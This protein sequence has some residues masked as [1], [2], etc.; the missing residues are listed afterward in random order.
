MFLV[1]QWMKQ[2][3]KHV[4]F[5]G[6]VSIGCRQGTNN[7]SAVMLSGEN[8]YSDLEILG[9]VDVTVQTLQ[10]MH[11]QSKLLKH[12]NIVCGENVWLLW[13]I[14]HKFRISTSGKSCQTKSRRYVIGYYDH[15]AN[16]FKIMRDPAVKALW[17]F[18]TFF[19]VFVDVSITFVGFIEVDIRAFQ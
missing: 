14:L 12:C 7:W 1:P 4:R 5:I 13:K 16:W 9:L 18:G 8:N 11:T 19:D 2:Q 17:D 15:H 6:S 3:D 10:H